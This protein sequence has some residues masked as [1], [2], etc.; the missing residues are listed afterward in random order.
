MEKKELKDGEEV[1]ILN[2]NYDVSDCYKKGVVVTK[3]YDSEIGKDP[4][5][6]LDSDYVAHMIFYPKTSEEEYVVTKLEFLELLRKQRNELVEKT[7]EL[8]DKA[9]ETNRI[10]NHIVHKCG[11]GDNKHVFGDWEYS[12][13]TKSY[14]IKCLICTYLERSYEEPKEI[15]KK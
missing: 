7:E 13:I 11:S 5:W 10:I 3:L 6:I 9:Y 14:T 12:D 2:F 4:Y 1:Y 15:K 8:R